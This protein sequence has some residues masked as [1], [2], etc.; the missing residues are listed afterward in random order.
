MI[1]FKIQHLKNQSTTVVAYSFDRNLKG[2][3]LPLIDEHN[4]INDSDLKTKQ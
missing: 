2:F 4:Y 1:R 3:F